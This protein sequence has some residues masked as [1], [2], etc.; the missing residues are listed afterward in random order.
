M[1]TYRFIGYLIYN[2]LGL[3]CPDLWDPNNSMAWKYGSYEKVM[4]QPLANQPNT[5]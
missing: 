1:N 2:S 4:C 3:A 5:R